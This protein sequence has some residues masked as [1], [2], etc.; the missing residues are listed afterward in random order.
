MAFVVHQLCACRGTN[1]FCSL[2]IFSWTSLSSQNRNRSGIVCTP[3]PRHSGFQCFFH[4]L[5]DLYFYT[6]LTLCCSGS[7]CARRL[8]L[9]T[10]NRLARQWLSGFAVVR[11]LQSWVAFFSI[12]YGRTGR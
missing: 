6:Q 4:A 10:S 12:L 7:L 1:S 3:T 5:P 9:I 11:S 2:A 8:A